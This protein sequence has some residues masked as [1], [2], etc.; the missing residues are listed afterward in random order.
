VLSR[1]HIPF[2]V[3]TKIWRVSTKVKPFFENPCPFPRDKLFP[4]NNTFFGKYLKNCNTHRENLW[5]IC[6]SFSATIYF[7]GTFWYLFPFFSYRGS[8][9][10]S[11]NTS[12]PQFSENVSLAVRSRGDSRFPVRINIFKRISTK[13]NPFFNPR[14]WQ[15]FWK[16]FFFKISNRNRYRKNVQN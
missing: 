1:G 12:L 7:V 9:K 8:K 11:K 13:V 10:N 4:K 6:R 15:F 3:R 14:P 2:Q 5:D 16:T